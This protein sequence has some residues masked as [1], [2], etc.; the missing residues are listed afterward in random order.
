MQRLVVRLGN[1]CS[2]HPLFPPRPNI[3]GSPNFFIKGKPIHREGDAW[4]VH[5]RTIP[6]F[7]CH[8]SVMGK[9]SAKFMANNKVVAF[10]G[11]PI[12]CGSICAEGED[13]LF[14]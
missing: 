13:G 11:D 14:G 4:D 1:I 3:Q 9:G 8:G 6:D 10:V 7:D 2:G 12:V 5:C